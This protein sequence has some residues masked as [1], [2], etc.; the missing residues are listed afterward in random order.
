MKIKFDTSGLGQS[1]WYEYLVR[2]IFGGSVTALAGIAAKH[3]GPEIGGL[4]LAF[5][6]ILPATATLL[7]KHEEKKKG[8]VGEQG[9]RRGRAVA[10]VDAAGAAMGSIGLVAFALVI[11]KRL[12]LSDTGLALTAASLAWIA[13]SLALWE[14]REILLRRTR[15]GFRKM[16]N[17]RRRTPAHPTPARRKLDE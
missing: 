3:F 8:L 9:T 15:A 6:A 12:P 1:R 2:F 11:W 7:E 10:G 13:T 17:R 5:P 14:L 4:F 16:S